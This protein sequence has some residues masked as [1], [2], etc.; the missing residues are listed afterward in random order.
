MLRIMLL[1]V[2][3][4]AVAVLVVPRVLSRSVKPAEGS[5]APDFTLPSRD[6]PVS[7]RDYRGEWVVLY[8]YPKDQTPG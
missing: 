3:V 7:L 5:M 6:G 2:A 8:F 4:V 1:L